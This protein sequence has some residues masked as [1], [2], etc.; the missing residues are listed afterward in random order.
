MVWKRNEREAGAHEVETREQF[1]GPL[2]EFLQVNDFLWQGGDHHEG[3]YKWCL[4][5]NSTNYEP[6]ISKGTLSPTISYTITPFDQNYQ[7]EQFLP[8]P[9][10][11]YRDVLKELQ[12][13]PGFSGRN[14]AKNSHLAREQ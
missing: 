2:I 10:E 7:Y 5:A 8:T 4:W 12:M 11:L 6:L 3:E 14:R 9:L 1:F 13:I